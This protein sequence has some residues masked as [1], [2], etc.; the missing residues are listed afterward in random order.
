MRVGVSVI[1]GVVAHSGRKGEGIDRC[2]PGP[3]IGPKQQEFWGRAAMP[4]RLETYRVEAYNTAK[5]S[6]NKMTT[7]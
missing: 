6:E 1:G 4:N 7:T 5:Q 2:S 3:T